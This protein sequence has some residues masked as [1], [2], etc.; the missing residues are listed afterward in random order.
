ML[1]SVRKHIA[2]PQ[3]PATTIFAVCSIASFLWLMAQ[4]LVHPIV[5]Y[6]LEVYLSFCPLCFR[7]VTDH[8]RSHLERGHAGIADGSPHGAAGKQDR[9]RDRRVDPDESG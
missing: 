6:A 7:Q 9:G 8:G 5:I 2:V 1:D 4:D 3:V